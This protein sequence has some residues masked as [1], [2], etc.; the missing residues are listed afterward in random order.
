MRSVAVLPL[1]ALSLMST[2]Q[3]APECAAVTEQPPNALG[4][5][6]VVTP[7]GNVDVYLESNGEPGLQRQPCERAGTLETVPADTL[8]VDVAG[9]RAE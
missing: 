5:Y 9:V 1:V 7:I 2:A 3:A 4:A 8:L 6:L